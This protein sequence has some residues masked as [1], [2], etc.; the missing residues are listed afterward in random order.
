MKGQ[1]KIRPATVDD[2]AGIAEVKSRV[3]P[4]EATDMTRI[5]TALSN[6]D[7]AAFVASHSGL[8]VGFI[9]SFA[10]FSS[11]GIKRWEVDLLAVNPDHRGQRLGE[12]LVRASTAAGRRKGATIARALVHVENAVS[13]RT[14][15]GC[16]YQ[17]SEVVCNLYVSASKLDALQAARSA[18]GMHLIP[19]NT[20]NYRGLWLEGSF[21]LARFNAAQKV[22]ASG[23]W[24]LVGAVVPINQVESN[25]AARDA[26]FAS[27][28]H[29]RWW[30]LIL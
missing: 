28:G 26:G 19:V 15:A 16:A 2:A 25:R 30:T 4:D 21:T 1:N 6:S 22:L 11:Q 12:R 23:N 7:H 24:D 27:K 3:W 8:I 17:P 10:T 20:F 9:D 5:A 14:F 29:F 18:Q 13:Q